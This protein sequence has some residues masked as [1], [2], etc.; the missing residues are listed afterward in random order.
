MD[1]C[2][3]KTLNWWL[4]SYFDHH[5]QQECIL[6]HDLGFTDTHMCLYIT[7]TKF[8]L[9]WTYSYCVLY[10]FCTAL[11]IPFFLKPSNGK[12][13]AKSWPT[14]LIS[15]HDCAAMHKCKHFIT[16][17]IILANHRYSVNVK[18]SHT[19]FPPIFCL[20]LAYQIKLQSVPDDKDI[21]S[22]FH[23]YWPNDLIVI[24]FP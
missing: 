7:R 24:I 9:N 6:N 20:P 10:S 13:K 4:W 11:F 2:W 8:S 21:W 12:K 3:P 19:I 22:L 5:P 18:F 1:S 15:R 17:Y 14:K 16:V 23:F